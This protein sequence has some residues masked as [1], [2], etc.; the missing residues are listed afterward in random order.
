MPVKKCPD[1]SKSKILTKFGNDRNKKD[2]LDRICRSCKSIANKISRKNNP[3]Y[4]INRGRTNK[5]RFCVARSSAKS[6]GK[7]W[8]LTI[9]QWIS[10][11]VGNLCHY[12]NGDLPEAGGALDRKNSDFGYILNNVVPCCRICNLIKKDILTYE[13]MI[14]LAKPLKE[15]AKIFKKNKSN[16]RA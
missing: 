2:G 16:Y 3:Q 5:Q 8:K 7:I 12:C 1:C 15:I 4:Y 11:V 10:V 6:R 13:E 9:D 14:K